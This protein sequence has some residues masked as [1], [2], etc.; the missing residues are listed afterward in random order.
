MRRETVFDVASLTKPIATATAVALLVEDGK[1][2]LDEPVASVLPVFGQADKEA[3]TLRHL[4]THSAGLKPWRPF[5]EE[6]LERE[7]KSFDRLVQ[8]PTGREWIVDRVLRS[9][10]V[11]QAAQS[12]QASRS[13]YEVGRLDFADVLESQMRLLDVE[14]Q[15]ERAQADRHASW[16]GLEALVGEE[17][18]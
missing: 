13:A 7:K 18:R 9:G 2:A 16:A 11:P 12:L 3:V 10:L 14:L 6:L 15:A 5:H 17:L 8:T 1:L 4:L